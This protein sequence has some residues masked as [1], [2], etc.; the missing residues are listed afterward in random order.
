MRR[1]TLQGD[2]GK[3]RIN[4]CSVSVN[5]AWLVFMFDMLAIILTT[6]EG[7]AVDEIGILLDDGG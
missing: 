3:Q 2:P 6:R 1:P 4:S 5:R 7:S